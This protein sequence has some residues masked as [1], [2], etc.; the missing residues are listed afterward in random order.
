[1]TL[2]EAINQAIRALDERARTDSPEAPYAPGLRDR[3]AIGTLT[4]L[5]TVLEMD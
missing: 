1:M 4:V 2:I 5:K 3:Q